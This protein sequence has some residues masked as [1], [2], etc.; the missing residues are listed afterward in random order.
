MSEQPQVKR[1]NWFR[2]YPATRNLAERTRNMVLSDFAGASVLDIGCNAGQMARWAVL[3]GARDVV[4]IDYDAA[5]IKLAREQVGDSNISYSVEDIDLPSCWR[6]LPKADVVLFLAVYLTKELAGPKEAILANAAA[7][8]GKVMYF[9]GHAAE[10]QGYTVERYVADIV[11][12][13]DFENVEYLGPTDAPGLRPLFRC[14]RK[15][16]DVNDGLA[17]IVM[18]MKD[19]C[20]KIVVVGKS[21]TGKSTLCEMV[22]NAMSRPFTHVVYDDVPPPY[23]SEPFILFDWRGLEY[24]PDA[25]C[26]FFVTCDE[27]E[28]LRRIDAQ[29]YKD[30]LLRSAPGVVTNAR[31]VFT[32]RT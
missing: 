25:D 3:Q 28:R 29:P 21:A 26:V 2:N 9:E 17:Q 6:S 13:T 12:Y 18:A 8:A 24:V 11:K 10:T 19:G 16:L 5:A 14:W 30:R 7:K 31:A 32:V 1:N 27:S 20:K 22:R 23:H 4:G 15:L